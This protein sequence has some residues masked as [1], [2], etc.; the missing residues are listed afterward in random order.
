MGQ[1]IDSGGSGN[2][3]LKTAWDYVHLNPARAQLL[4]REDRLLAYPWRSFCWYLAA[5]EH[6]PSWVRVDRLL[7]EHGIQPDSAAGRQEFE[8]RME[9]RRWEEV[10]EA[11]L[12][13]LRRGW[14]L[15]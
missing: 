10:D 14:C 11:E 8:Q 1:T 5:P 4:G 13:K 15:Q 9:A 3:Y 2:G 12:K 7:G 6:R